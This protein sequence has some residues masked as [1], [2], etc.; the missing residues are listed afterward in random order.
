MTDGVPMTAQKRCQSLRLPGDKDVWVFIIGELMMFG[1]FFITYI[2]YRV[3]NVA[4]YNESQQLLSSTLGTLNT[5]FLITSSWAVMLA[6]KSVKHNR[7]KKGQRQLLA[8]ILFAI[9]FIVVKYFEYSEKLDAGYGLTTNEFFMFYY[10]FTMVHLAHVIGGGIILTVLWFNMR[11]GNYHS[12]R[13][14][15]LETGACYWHL[16]DLVWIVMFPLLYLLR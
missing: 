3:D 15:G 10:V 9:G 1:A 13:M 6:V 5:L 4:L 7:H 16:V 2:I 12:R 14:R 8:A 11:A